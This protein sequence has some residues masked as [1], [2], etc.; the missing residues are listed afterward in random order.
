MKPLLLLISCVL[1][2]LTSQA[3]GDMQLI[4]KIVAIIGDEIVLYSDLQAAE[5]E[6]TKGQGKLTPEQQC[7]LIEDQ[8]YQKLLL[9]HA[10]LDSVTVSDEEVN[11]QVERRLSY[12]MNMFGSAEQ[13]EAYYGKSVAQMK[14]EYFDLIKEQL[15]VQKQQG[16]ITRN[17]KTTPAD[18]LRFYQSLPAD[19]LP[20]IGEQ[21]S[22]S[23]IVVD[24]VI[25]ETARQRII[26]FLD[27]IRQDIVAGRTS[28]TLQAARHSEDPGSR[29]KG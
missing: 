12:F 15:L 7:M 23:K 21:V 1:C 17:V 11:A 28:M 29:Y 16:E 6:L 26:N 14:E 9:H 3:Q 25:R 2:G 4:D 5:M 13:F 22:Y 19:S 20:L 24:P 8:A 27:S 18:V 10:K